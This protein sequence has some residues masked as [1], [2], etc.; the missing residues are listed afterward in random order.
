MWLMRVLSCAIELNHVESYGMWQVNQQVKRMKEGNELE[1]HSRSY[2][3]LL[4]TSEL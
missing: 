3:D 1:L 4:K 2:Y